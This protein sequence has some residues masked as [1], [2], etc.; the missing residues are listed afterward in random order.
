MDYFGCIKM[1]TKRLSQK[2]MN[3]IKSYEM[4]IKK[5]SRGYL[6]TDYYTLTLPKHLLLGLQKYLYDCGY[7]YHTLKYSGMMETDLKTSSI[8]QLNDF[9][10][11]LGEKSIVLLYLTM[12]SQ[13]KKDQKYYLFTGH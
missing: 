4:T 11:K 12:Y 2:K 3:K 9:I 6:K 5:L 8:Y 1:V 7:E 13:D 10:P